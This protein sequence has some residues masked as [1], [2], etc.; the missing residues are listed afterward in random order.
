MILTGVLMIFDGKQVKLVATDTHR[1]AVRAGKASGGKGNATA[2]LPARAMN[3]LTRLAGDDDEVTISLAQGQ[4]RFEVTRAN[5]NGPASTTTMVTRLIESGAGGT[6]PA[7]G[8]PMPS[9]LL[10]D[11]DGHLVSLERLLENGPVVIAMHRGHWCP[12]CRINASAL[13]EVA[14]EVRRLGGEIVAITPELQSFNAR[15]RDDASA[16][17]PVLT[18]LDN[19][20]AL[21][22]NVA[23]WV[24]E[25]KKQAMSGAGWDI[26]VFHGNGAW[27]LPIPATFVV[28]TDGLVKARYVD[29]DYRRRMPIEPILEGLKKP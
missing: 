18:D 25:E 10:P 3:E 16:S 29:P 8:D 4:A 17:F 7:V 21:E 14:G 13:A 28:G 9:F 15:L 12:Y 11:Q 22:S 1:L 6:A 19:A 27:V 23:I 24:G 2:V 5:P 20:Y 26:S